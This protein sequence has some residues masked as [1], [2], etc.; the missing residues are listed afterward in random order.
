MEGCGVLLHRRADGSIVA[1]EGLFMNDEFIGPVMAC[2]VA[3]A[4]SAA[5][6]ADRAAQMARAFVLPNPKLRQL[7]MRGQ[8][9][10]TEAAAQSHG[11]G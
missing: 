10:Q 2:P 7:F 4:R 9:P 3:A 8:S 5:T 6:E 11:K 1:E